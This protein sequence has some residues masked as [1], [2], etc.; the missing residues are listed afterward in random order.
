MG[1]AEHQANVTRSEQLRLQALGPG[2]LQN[3]SGVPQAVGVPV[4]PLPQSV[5]RQISIDHFRRLRASAI[6]N[7]ISP[8][9]Y[10]D[11]LRDLGTGGF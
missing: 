8:S 4:A 6:A 5:V 1:M 10:V 2:Y 3:Y 11:A 9:C 7:G